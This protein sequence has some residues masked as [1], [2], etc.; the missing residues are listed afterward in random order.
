MQNVR[1]LIETA[2]VS[3]SMIKKMEY[4]RLNQSLTVYF[5]SGNVY[6]YLAVPGTLFDELL[7]ADSIGSLFYNK[8]RQHPEEYS[9]TRIA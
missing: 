2:I 3:S 6:R 7:N 1:S 9:C 4:E 5:V 8:I